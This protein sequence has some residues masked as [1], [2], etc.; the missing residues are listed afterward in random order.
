MKLYIGFIKNSVKKIIAYRINVCAKTLS[1]F[2][3]LYVQVSV[4]IAFYSS[5]IINSDMKNLQQITTYV[6]ISNLLSCLVEFNSIELLN[7]KIKTGDIALD[8]MKPFNFMMYIF[9]YGLGDIIINVCFQ[10]IPMALFSVIFWDFAI[11]NYSLIFIFI[12]SALLSVVISFLFSYFIG[13]LAF[14]FF[15]TWPINMATKAIYKIMSG[16]WIPVWLFPVF[17]KDISLC[18]PFQSIYYA[19]AFIL[20]QTVLDVSE[21]LHLLQG[22]LLWIVIMGCIV[23]TVWHCGRKKLVI[24]GG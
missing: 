16:A 22:Q 6:I 11:A 3:Y 10:A 24:Q 4:W 1:K 15:V 12:C 8:I 20:S 21:T 17:L 7:Q 2:F 9:C 19:P 5:N 14:W 13:I 23:M 18:L